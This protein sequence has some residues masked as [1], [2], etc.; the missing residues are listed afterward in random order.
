MTSTP[1]AASSASARQVLRWAGSADWRSRKRAAQALA[2]HAASKA[3]F[4]ALAGLLDDPDTAV[5]GA[6]AQS[7][8]ASGGTPGLAAVL[9]ALATSTDNAGYHIRDT[10]IA[11]S[12]HGM[13]LLEQ[14]REI[15][16]GDTPA[17]AREGAREI[18]EA[19]LS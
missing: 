18:M 9:S 16:A 8:A 1:D 11:L 15:I 2:A 3:G 5:I 7:L 14:C 12:L 19:L 4:D 13:P 10:L 17:D 6:A